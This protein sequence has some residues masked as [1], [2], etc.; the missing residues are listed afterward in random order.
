[1]SEAEEADQVSN[2]SNATNDTN[3]SNETASTADLDGLVADVTVTADPQ[4]PALLAEVLDRFMAL[5]V[6]AV[7]LEIVET[8]ADR[9]GNGLYLVIVTR[10]SL[11]AVESSTGS[12]T[13]MSWSAGS[14]PELLMPSQ[15]ATAGS[16][17]HFRSPWSSGALAFM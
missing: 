5:S 7:T 17:Q 16:V 10:L 13:V 4:T 15:P 2:D 9:V 6:E 3:V 14:Q 8:L 12:S 1:M 11:S